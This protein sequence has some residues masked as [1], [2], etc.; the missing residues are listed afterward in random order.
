[1]ATARYCSTLE[2]SVIGGMLVQAFG[3]RRGG[4]GVNGR[5]TQAVMVVICPGITMAIAPPHAH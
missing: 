4:A 3:P 5:R 2:M 1:V